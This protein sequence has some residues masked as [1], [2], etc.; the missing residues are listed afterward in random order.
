METDSGDLAGG[1]HSSVPHAA[2]EAS[3]GVEVRVDAAAVS[4]LSDATLHRRLAEIGPI[5][6]GARVLPTIFNHATGDDGSTAPRAP[7]A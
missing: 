3:A 6:A 4:E 2:H 7:P 1:G 5:A